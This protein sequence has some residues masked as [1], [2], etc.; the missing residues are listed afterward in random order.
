MT[1]VA[2][3][4]VSNIFFHRRWF[5]CRN[6]ICVYLKLHVS[7]KTCNLPYKLKFYSYTYMSEMTS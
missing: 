6:A 3:E 1:V 5:G 2:D 7:K 4:G